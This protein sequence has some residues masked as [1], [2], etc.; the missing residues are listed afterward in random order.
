ML[1]LLILRA[2]QRW[3]SYA[4]REVR[5][6]R[7]NAEFSEQVFESELRSVQAQIACEET[8]RRFRVAR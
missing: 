6:T 3:L 7:A 1:R 8:E 5:Q 4:L 2:R